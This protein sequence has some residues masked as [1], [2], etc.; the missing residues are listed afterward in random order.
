MCLVAKSDSNCDFSVSPFL[1]QFYFQ[2][3][4]IHLGFDDVFW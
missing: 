1:R 2:M 3:C 4:G